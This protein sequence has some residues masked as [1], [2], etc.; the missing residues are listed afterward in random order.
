MKDS[1]KVSS[2]FSSPLIDVS[3][4]KERNQTHQLRAKRVIV[5]FVW[6]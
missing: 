3:Q 5:C 1:T 4:K 2:L 6:L